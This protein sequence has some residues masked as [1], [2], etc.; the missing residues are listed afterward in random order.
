MFF[1]FLVM[2]KVRCEYFVFFFTKLSDSFR[3]I[4]VVIEKNTHTALNYFK[5]ASYPKQ[6][7]N[8]I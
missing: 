2:E 7:A 1:Y 3:E 6:V 5:N 8:S 4:P